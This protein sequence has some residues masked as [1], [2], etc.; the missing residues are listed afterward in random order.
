MTFLHFDTSVLWVSLYL[1]ASLQTNNNYKNHSHLEII[2]QSLI[3]S[4]STSSRFAEL[5]SIS[6]ICLSF[7]RVIRTAE[8]I[9]GSNPPFMDILYTK[10]CKKN[11]HG[12]L[13]GHTPPSSHSAHTQTQPPTVILTNILRLYRLDCIITHEETLKVFISVNVDL[14]LY[15]LTVSYA[16][17]SP[18]STLL[19][20]F[21][22]VY[23]V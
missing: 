1:L 8:K 20:H 10:Q 18:Y 4:E 15:L 21:Y 13:P 16:M 5:L 7:Q 3:D 2:A 19:H 22:S 9:A 6:Q 11:A 14:M 17:L 23:M 12:L